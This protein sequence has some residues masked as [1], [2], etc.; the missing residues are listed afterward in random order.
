[1]QK[2]IVDAMNWRY[3][4]AQFDTNKKI[5]DEHMESLMEA[6]RLTPS[7][8]GLQPWKFIVVSNPE[9]KQK[10]RAAGYDQAAFTDA[11]HMVVLAVNTGVDASYIERYIESVSTLRGIAKENLTGFSDMMN[12]AVAMR[13]PAEVVEWSSRQVYI[14]L[15]VMVAAA[16]VMAIDSHAMEGFDKDQFDEILGLTG[17]GFHSL[18]VNALGYRSDADALAEA[19]KVRFATEE[20]IVEKK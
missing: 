3:A 19:P 11:S 1:M 6:V 18:V 2:N 14:A 9:L 5:S 8:F 20:M 12:G 7:S 10:M 4:V 16:S 13:T 15:G 17:T